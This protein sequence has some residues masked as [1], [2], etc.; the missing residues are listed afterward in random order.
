MPI[1]WRN[2]AGTLKLIALSALLAG[3]ALP[4]SAQVSTNTRTEDIGIN[5]AIGAVTATVWSIARGRGFK[6]A[7]LQGLIGGATI[8]V[9]RQVAASPFSGS[10]LVGRELSA[11][12]ISALTTAGSDH[13]TLSFPIGPVELQLT[14]GRSFDWRVNATYAVA[15]VRNSVS[16]T[17]HI[18]A[19]LSLYSG[20]FV[21]RDNRETL[22]TSNGEARGSEFFG[23][24]KIAKSAFANSQG[25][26]NVLYHENVH[27]LQD[28]YLA[29]AIA[30]P[31]E[32]LILD[33]TSIG[34]RITRH[35]DV[36]LLSLG[37]NGLANSLVPYASRPWEREAYALTPRHNY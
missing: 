19:T 33:Q 29:F 12:G 36:G 35:I 4:V 18:D 9:A 37:L 23:G 7:V 20:T 11:V 10:G 16:R 13:T 3:S 22:H 1:L 28:D 25:T 15:A 14:D 2:A 8:G 21:F 24:I 5:A 32:K 26:P 30:N 6:R 31:I 34:R 27:V 17:T